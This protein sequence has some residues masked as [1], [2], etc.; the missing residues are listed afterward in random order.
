MIPPMLQ[1]LRSRW[2]HLRQEEGG[3]L[4]VEA[5]IMFP[6]LF[7]ALLSML[8]FFD[9]YRQ[10]SLN[11]KASYTISDML[12]REV[13]PINAAYLDGAMNLF[14]ELARSA[15]PPRMRVTVV[16]YDAA[17]KRFFRD[18]SH[19]RGGVPVLSNADVLA[20]QHKLPLVPNNE[21]LI[22]VETWAD[23]V[24]PFNVG[25]ARQ[26]LYNF[27]FTRP[28]FAPQVKFSA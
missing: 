20:M 22:V 14:A 7:W 5:V 24:P 9:A 11:V 6:L 26:D 18:W 4:T 13:E 12:S 10:S 19:Q 1:R 25:L 21:R 2:R 28:R 3:S 8:V 17:Q 27:V 23:Y 15:N 16:Y